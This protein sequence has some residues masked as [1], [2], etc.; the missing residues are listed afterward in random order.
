MSPGSTHRF[1]PEDALVV[2]YT[3]W[4][5]TQR[6][7]GRDCPESKSKRR[8]PWWRPSLLWQKL[9][10]K[11][12][13]RGCSVKVHQFEYRQSVGTAQRIVVRLF[14][15]PLSMSEDVHSCGCNR[16]FRDKG[17]RLESR[18]HIL[19]VSGRATPVTRG[20]ECGATACII[21]SS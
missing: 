2:A 5:R 6:E 3:Y 11:V 12:M 8:W 15:M 20:C 16:A 9:R 21:G 13:P 10:R 14:T 19:N 4:N 1:L 7:Y 17:I 18:W